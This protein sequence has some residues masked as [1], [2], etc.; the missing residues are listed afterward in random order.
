MR[1]RS[2]V[3]RS[4]RSFLVIERSKDRFAHGRSF[5]KDQRDRFAPVWS[6]QTSTRANRSHRSFKTIEEQRSTG[7]GKNCQKHT[8]NKNMNRS[9]LWLKDRFDHGQYFLKIEKSE[10]SKDRK[11]ERSNSHPCAFGAREGILLKRP[12]IEKMF[13]QSCNELFDFKGFSTEK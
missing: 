8:K 13:Q 7:T 4:N 9:F 11:I 6:F 2:S 12:E 5:F 1:I 10:R 3:F